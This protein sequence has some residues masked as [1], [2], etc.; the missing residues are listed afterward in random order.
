MPKL[1]IEVEKLLA[2]QPHLSRG[3]AMKLVAL[4]REKKRIKKAV[5]VNRSEGQKQRHAGGS[6]RGS[7]RALRGGRVSPRQLPLIKREPKPSPR[8]L[9]A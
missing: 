6:S 3:E 1:E 5:R 9:A 7:V 8:S 4:R 2:T